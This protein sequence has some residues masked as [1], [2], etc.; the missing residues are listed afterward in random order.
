MRAQSVHAGRLARTRLLEHRRDPRDRRA[1]QPVA[2]APASSVCRRPGLHLL[3]G[4]A[5]GCDQEGLSA[6]KARHLGHA[7]SADRSEGRRAQLRGRDP[8]EQPVGKGRHRL[9]ARKRVRA[10]TA[11]S[12]ADGVQPGR[13][14]RDGRRRQ[15]ADGRRPLRAVRA[16][17]R[18]ARRR[19]ARAP[20]REGEGAAATRCCCA[21][22]CPEGRH[23]PDRGPRQRTDRRLHPS[24]WPAPPGTLSG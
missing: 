22:T 12:P 19:T 18:R 24:P 21:P 15:G 20:G 9:S 8:G 16:R 13:A 1:L 10:R 23:S 14:A 11:A 3:L 4:L 2:R 6:R 5:P 7:L 17:V